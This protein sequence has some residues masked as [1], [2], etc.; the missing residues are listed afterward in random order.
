MPS[1]Y[2]TNI[3]FELMATGEKN[4]LW[5]GITNTN[6]GT[7]LEEAIMGA[8]T[9][10]MA[11]ANQTIAITNG[12]SSTG[13]CVYIK[14]TGALTAGRNLTVPTV[15]KDYVVEN[16]T[17]GGFDVTVKTAAGTGIAVKP[18]TKRAVYADATNV[19]E[20]LSGFGAL[21]V[22]SLNGLTITTSTGTFT[23]TN[24]KTFAVSNT[25]T[26]TGTDAA[27]YDLGTGGAVCPAGAV[28]DFAGSSAPTG[29][30]LCDGSSQL[31]ATYPALFTAIGTTYGSV[32]GTHF[33]LPDLRGRVVA[34]RDDMGGSAA[35]RLTATTMTPSGVA[36]A[37]VGGTQTNTTTMTS[38]G[39]NT[40]NFGAGWLG[41]TSGGWSGATLAAAG[42]DFFALTTASISATT[43]TQPINNN[44]GITVSGTSAAFSDVQPT[45]IMNKIIKT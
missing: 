43:I 23:V 41:T 39:S 1:T 24:A 19:V 7:L 37:A 10:A 6:L 21:V 28:I 15:N 16:A 17:T 8:A 3:K 22:T 31:R 38:T 27:S 44:F 33:T 45:M 26:L 9:V 35:S 11:D 12:A 2:S 36:L 5:G 25:I 13:R 4:N 30:L 34:G 20:S 42:G 18:S 40:I 32:D 14:C 29:W